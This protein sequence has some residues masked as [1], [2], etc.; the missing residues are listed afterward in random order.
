MGMKIKY[1]I[2]DAIRDVLYSDETAREDKRFVGLFNN[3]KQGQSTPHAFRPLPVTDLTRFVA[4]RR[5]TT[6]DELATLA[7]SSPARSLAHSLSSP[8]ASATR[9][10]NQAEDLAH[11]TATALAPTASAAKA[12]STQALATGATYTSQALSSAA[13]L[14]VE[15][16]PSER[17]MRSLRRSASKGLLKAT[18][19]GVVLVGEAQ[20]KSS[21]GW[22][23]ALALVALEAVYVLYSNI[24][25]ELAVSQLCFLLEWLSWC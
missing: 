11:Q 24:G 12:Y 1:E 20:Q 6:Y 21:D 25:Y 23:I 16:V 5:S 18:R 7:Q 2:Q 17:Q 4:G 3:T 9:L 14:A 22:N 13:E 15:K 19:S 8:P 10:V